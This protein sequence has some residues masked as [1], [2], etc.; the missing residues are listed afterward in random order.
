MPQSSGQSRSAVHSSKSGSEYQDRQTTALPRQTSRR[1]LSSFMSTCHL[2]IDSTK[3]I[4]LSSVIIPRRK[5][6]CFLFLRTTRVHRRLNI[7]ALRIA[8]FFPPLFCSFRDFSFTGIQEVEFSGKKE[9]MAW[10][11]PRALAVC[12]SASTVLM[13]SLYIWPDPRRSFVASVVDL[14]R[15]SFDPELLYDRLAPCHFKRRVASFTVTIAVSTFLVSRCSSQSSAGGDGGQPSFFNRYFLH[16]AKKFCCRSAACT[17]LLFFGPI[18]E[19]VAGFFCQTP[20]VFTDDDDEHD[21]SYCGERMLMSDSNP[22]GLMSRL[23]AAWT[24]NTATEQQRLDLVR[25]LVVAPL[26]EEVFFRV[27]MFDLLRRSSTFSDT[28]TADCGLLSPV[29]LRLLVASSFFFVL[30][31]VHHASMYAIQAYRRDNMWRCD[32]DDNE[33]S[34][35]SR[36]V[37]DSDGAVRRAWCAG[38]RDCAVHCGVV[39]VFGL[40]SGLY[41]LSPICGGNALATAVAHAICNLLGEPRLLFLRRR[42]TPSTDENRGKWCLPVALG[43][44]HVIG[45][46]GFV[47]CITK[48][49]GW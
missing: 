5:S 39:F 16:D 26:G 36:H 31:H 11:A 43:A 46:A 24:K 28:A 35:A 15:A 29:R 42:R 3:G 12:A 21:E 37:M 17:L 25:V 40:L 6:L 48:S 45:L 2:G 44:A 27:V 18:A 19:R 14:R 38:V 30:S 33:E 47:L 41:F 7:D 4:S 32:S 34:K 20:N 9:R 49:A 23:S 22:P 10:S 13:L 1:R 8:A